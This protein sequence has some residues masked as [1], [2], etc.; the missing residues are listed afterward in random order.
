ML[1]QVGH[2]FR[3]TANFTQKD[4]KKQKKANDKDKKAGG[5]KFAAKKDPTWKPWLHPC[6]QEIDC[7]RICGQRDH[8]YTTES[9]PW[10]E[11]DLECPEC[12]TWN[13]IERATP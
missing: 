12:R 3:P 9:S 13:A 11:I 1:T 8:G 10:H 4:P 5:K 6:H 7:K 2:E